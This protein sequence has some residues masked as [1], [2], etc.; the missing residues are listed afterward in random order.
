MAIHACEAPRW[1]ARS[2]GLAWRSSGF[3]ER[4]W[5]GTCRPPAEC[6]KPV[7]SAS[8]KIKEVPKCIPGARVGS[9]DV[10]YPTQ[11]SWVAGAAT[12]GGSCMLWNAKERCHDGCIDL[13]IRADC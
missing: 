11:R 9:T 2:I 3:R 13:S 5:G 1:G 6:E 12:W 8:S 10:S 4:G 7:G